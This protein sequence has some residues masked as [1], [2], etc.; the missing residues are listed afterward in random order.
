MTS[1]VS[2]VLRAATQMRRAR[3]RPTRTRLR[4]RRRTLG[5]GAQIEKHG[6]PI[7]C[8]FVCFVS[9]LSVYRVWLWLVRVGLERDDAR[10]IRTMWHDQAKA[11]PGLP[12]ILEQL[13]QI[14]PKDDL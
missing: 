10:Q 5:H 9:G 13:Q 2:H 8:L 11:R 3:S 12:F 7:V 14:F 4:P 6:Q 1:R